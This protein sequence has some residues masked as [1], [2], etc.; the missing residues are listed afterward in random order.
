MTSTAIHRWSGE[1]FGFIHNRNFFD[2]KGRY[3]GWEDD[4]K[5]VWRSDGVYLGEIVDSNYILRNTGMTEPGRRVPKVP[6][7]SHIPIVPRVGRVGRV[8]RLGWT[9]ALGDFE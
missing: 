6:P 2:A 1:H 5:M 8:P 3:V 4:K 9:D 7:V